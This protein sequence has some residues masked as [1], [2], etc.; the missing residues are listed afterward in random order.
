MATVPS[1]DYRDMRAH[2]GRS[3]RFAVG[4]SAVEAIC[5]VGAVVLA[6]IGLAHAEW[7]ILTP[8]AT[9]LAGVALV[10]AGAAFRARSLTS[11]STAAGTSFSESEAGIPAEV[12]GGVTGIVLGIL[13]ILGLV[14]NILVSTA[15]VVFGSSILLGSIASAGVRAWASFSSSPE[16]PADFF[17][18]QG[19]HSGRGAQLLVG[20]ATVI[21]GIIALVGESNFG[22]TLNLISLLVVGGG[23]LLTATEV[24]GRLMNA[25][26]R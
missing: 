6:I 21:L 5:G 3:T 14:P 16:A 2:E 1:H 9:I 15:V 23:V 20:L 19:I 26:T 13:A 22:P 24:A 25:L 4:E 17:R 8:I 11:T 12:L 18:G 7:T 10:F